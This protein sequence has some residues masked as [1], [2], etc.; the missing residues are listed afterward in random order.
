MDQEKEDTPQFLSKR[1]GGMWSEQKI[2]GSV[3]FRGVFGSEG[4]ASR[5]ANKLNSI[6]AAS[7]SMALPQEVCSIAAR[8]E[9]K[10]CVLSLDENSVA[11]CWE[12]LQPKAAKGPLDHA[13]RR[14]EPRIR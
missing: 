11:R 4:A 7:C 8:P 13:E 6:G 14:D 3:Y 5:A 1:L 9:P 2:N 10:Y 12:R